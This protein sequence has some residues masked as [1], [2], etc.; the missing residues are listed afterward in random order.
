MKFKIYNAENS[1]SATVGGNSTIRVQR[2]SGLI[3]FSKKA[4]ENIGITQGD[5]IVVVQDEENP[6]NFYI[7]KTADPKGF[8]IRFKTADLGASFNCSTLVNLILL[9]KK[10][11]YVSYT[12]GAA[13]EI[14]GMVYHLI[15]TSKPMREK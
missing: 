6:E 12:I 5:R 2:N 15:V 9:N 7:H 11:N 3:S 1:K 13:H 10:F 14:D 8:L 4:S